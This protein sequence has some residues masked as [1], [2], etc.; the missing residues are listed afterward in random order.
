MKRLLL[1]SDLLS[2]NSSSCF[3]NCIVPGGI[4]LVDKLDVFPNP[5][6]DES[7]S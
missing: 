2:L 1:F 4:E 5:S 6:N 3:T 7:N